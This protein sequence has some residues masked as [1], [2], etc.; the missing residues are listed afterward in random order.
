MPNDRGTDVPRDE[1]LTDDQLA[2]ELQV[3]VQTIREWR[4]VGKAPPFVKLGRSVRTRRSALERWLD[5]RT[6]MST[7]DPGP[8]AP[9]LGARRRRSA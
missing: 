1:L 9:Q 8:A 6:R 3:K 2:A 7:S 5:E 4:C